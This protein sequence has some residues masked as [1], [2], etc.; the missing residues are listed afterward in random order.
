MSGHR[1]ARLILGAG[2]A[3]GMLVSGAAF[4][5][6]Q[7]SASAGPGLH[8]SFN[9]Y[10]KPSHG[11][12]TMQGSTATGSSSGTKHKRSLYGEG[13]MQSQF[14][15]SGMAANGSAQCSKG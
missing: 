13:G 1:P 15:S 6:S 5:G 4:A 7:S 9:M 2:L 8:S 11:Q 10:A 12:G 3:V 14:G